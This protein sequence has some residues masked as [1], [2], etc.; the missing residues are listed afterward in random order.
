MMFDEF[1]TIQLVGG[2]E[3]GRLLEWRGGDVVYLNGPR[4]FSSLPAFRQG[5]YSPEIEPDAY[6]RSMKSQHLFVFQP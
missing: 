1:E 6:R 4:C 3:D 2:P 5:P